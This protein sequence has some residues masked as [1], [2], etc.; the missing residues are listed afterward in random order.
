MGSKSTTNSLKGRL[1]YY[2]N[3]ALSEHFLLRIQKKIGGGF[4]ALLVLRDQGAG[5]VVFSRLQ[6]LGP[7]RRCFVRA[8][9]PTQ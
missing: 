3:Y 6:Y 9:V 8:H 2:G 4:F 1:I 5:G 7:F